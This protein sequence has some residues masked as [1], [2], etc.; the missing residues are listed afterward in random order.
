MKQ[1]TAHQIGQPADARRG[2]ALVPSAVVPAAYP[3]AWRAGWSTEVS[4][5]PCPAD[6]SG[7]NR[8]RTGMGIA[9]FTRKHHRWPDGP[10]PR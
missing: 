1:L 3:A 5:V 10:P 9:L 6:A 8:L 4:T 2:R 7:E